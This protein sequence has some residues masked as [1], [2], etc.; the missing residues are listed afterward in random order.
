[1]Y[2]TVALLSIQPKL[3]NDYVWSYNRVLILMLLFL[4]C[5][6]LWLMILAQSDVEQ[7]HFAPCY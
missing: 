6:I 5:F 4:N 7:L 2:F 3:S 1:M